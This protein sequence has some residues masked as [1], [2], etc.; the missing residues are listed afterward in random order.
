MIL[1]LL[2]S[3]LKLKSCID[4]DFG[5][6]LK[7]G[8]SLIK[9]YINC[10]AIYGNI[11]DSDISD[12][13]Y[14]KVVNFEIALRMHAN[15]DSLLNNQ[16]D[17]I[18]VINKLCSFKNLPQTET[19]KLQKGRVFLNMI[20]HNKKQFP[21]WAEGIKSFEEAYEILMKNKFNIL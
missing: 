7:S 21:S 6:L 10:K 9:F 15:N 11:N 14:C 4:C 12:D 13:V 2:H 5:S 18:D 20:K 16:E 1:R 19:D 3:K 8:P 17:L